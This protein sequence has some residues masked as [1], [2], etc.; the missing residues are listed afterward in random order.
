M[1][2]M[3]YG[4]SWPIAAAHRSS[5]LLALHRVLSMSVTDVSA[6]V[7]TAAASL[8]ISATSMSLPAD[9][10]SCRATRL[11]SHASAGSIWTGT[12]WLATT[13]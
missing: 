7:S 10:N 5:R 6:C 2:I 13:A 1:I 8:S 3:P 11:A 4:W 9:M 12:G